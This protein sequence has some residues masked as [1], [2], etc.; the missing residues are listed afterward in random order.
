MTV[1]T[2]SAPGCDAPAVWSVRAVA[3]RF[4]VTPLPVCDA[5]L[6]PLIDRAAHV[7]DIDLTVSPW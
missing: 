3:S 2:C 1:A 4:T 7:P 6:V 5:H